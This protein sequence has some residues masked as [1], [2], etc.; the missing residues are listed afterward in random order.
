[1]ISRSNYYI[2]FSVASIV[3]IIGLF[4]K[5]MDV[6]AAQYA[7][8]SREMFSNHHYLQVFD[9]GENY[10]D[11]P[12]LLFWL[13]VLSFKIFGVSTFAYKLPSFLFTL[14]GVYATFRLAKYLYSEETGLLAALI[15]YTCQAF[16]LF[17]NDVRTDTLLTAFVIFSCWQLILFSDSKKFIHLILGFSGVALA[18]MSKGPIGAVVPASALFAQFV[19]KREWKKFLQW[20]WIMGLIITMILL[21]PMLTG[22][23]QQFG[24]DGPK[25][26]FWTQS[27][28]RITGGSPWR[29]DAGYFYFI[30]VFLWS[31]L[32]WS[33][34]VTAA[35]LF[36]IVK[37]FRKRF[38]R[39]TL[40]EYYSLGGFVIPYIALSLSHYKLPHYIFVLYPLAA[41]FTAA[42]LLQVVSQNKPLAG[43]FSIV[44]LI[45]SIGVL[46]L[47]VIICT[48]WFPA[49][50]IFLWLPAVIGTA[51]CFWWWLKPANLISRI[52]LPSA[53]AAIVVNFLLDAHAYPSLLK[54]QSGSTLAEIANEE[55]VPKDKVYYCNYRNYSFDFYFQQSVPALNL[56][57]VREKIKQQK[58]IYIIGS[59]SLMRMVRKENLPVKKIFP[60]NDFHV[61]TL[62]TKFLNRTTR[63]STV[64][65]MY[66]VEF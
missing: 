44:Q 52:V 17:N 18:L 45:I 56:Q 25:F 30:H 27:F 40:I 42:F 43:A 35:L 8:I 28:G 48:L 10:L 19:M 32:P 4:V 62:T 9:H 26:F 33:I 61:T 65:K 11:K 12:P 58:D 51:L 59:D 1:M 3:Y 21:L 39:D 37:I 47:A 29:N 2:L 14:L 66:L 5:V 31:F 41:I 55:N 7:S 50:N 34:I 54:Y 64:S 16:Y 20:Q 13:S 6:D 38:S 53:F 49:T 60:A 63:D 46:T 23:Y 15:V 24:N 22:L 57:Q 36:S